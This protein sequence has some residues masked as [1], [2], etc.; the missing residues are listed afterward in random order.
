[1][2]VE[3]LPAHVDTLRLVVSCK[4]FTPANTGLDVASHYPE[5]GSTFKAAFMKTA[6]WFFAAKAMELTASNPAESCFNI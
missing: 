4:M 1:M 6:I 5:M 2:Y 3:I